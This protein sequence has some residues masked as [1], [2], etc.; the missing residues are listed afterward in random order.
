MKYPDNKS[1]YL[2]VLL[3]KVFCIASI[4]FFLPSVTYSSTEDSLRTFVLFPKPINSGELNLSIGLSM[5][6]VP[7]VIVEEGVLQLPMAELRAKYGLPYNLFLSSKMNFVYLTNQ[8]QLGL[9]WAYSINKFSVALSDNFGYW[10]GF[11][12]FQGFDT[13]AMGLINYPTLTIGYDIDDLFLSL[14]G[15]AIFSISQHTNFG[16]ASLGRVN[17]KLAGFAFTLAVEEELWKNQ[18]LIFGA[19][20]Q[21]ALPSYQIWLAFSSSRRWYIFPELF[22]GYEL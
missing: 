5:T 3:F 21:Y 1:N 13:F 17:T 7:R 12:D 9:G 4:S 8:V 22:L 10:F 19:R 11:A 20:F 2:S 18:Y 6:I 14:S 15:E 16:E